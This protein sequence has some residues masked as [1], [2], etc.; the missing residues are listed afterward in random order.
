RT[1]RRYEL[2][3]NRGMTQRRQRALQ[4]LVVRIDLARRVEASVHDDVGRQRV[5]RQYP[6]LAP[7]VRNLADLLGVDLGGDVDLYRGAISR[8]LSWR[9]PA[10]RWIIRIDA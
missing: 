1:E 3:I 4:A 10:R 6:M 2:A 8:L 9:L 7:V 5:A